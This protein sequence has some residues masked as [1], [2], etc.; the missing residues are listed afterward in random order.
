MAFED[1][2]NE[3]S[4]HCFL[5]S[6][7]LSAFIQSIRG[8]DPQPDEASLRRDTFNIEGH[9]FI[10]SPV[11]VEDGARRP[12]VFRQGRFDED[13]VKLRVHLGQFE[14]DQVRAQ[15]H[16]G[17]VGLLDDVIFETN[18]FLEFGIFLEAILQSRVA[19]EVL[20]PLSRVHE[21]LAVIVVRVLRLG[22]LLTRKR[23]AW[24]VKTTTGYKDKQ[25]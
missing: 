8:S 1:S 3:I 14:V 20:W 15:I 16:R 11:F 13:D 2:R 4:P 25:V 12:L 7:H 10:P 5:R 6:T 23:G 22:A 19:D 17:N 18:E 24:D 21:V 9:D